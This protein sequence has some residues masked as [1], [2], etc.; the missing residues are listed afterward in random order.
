MRF[1]VEPRDV[2]IQAAARRLGLTEEQF[3]AVADKL[4]DR[5]FPRADPDTGNFD[6]DAI[7]QWRRL[8]NRSLFDLVG[9]PA[10]R[11]AG[12]VVRER[13]ANRRP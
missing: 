3:R 1:H 12:T 7:D 4:Y 8:R 10:A 9:R 5:G 2:P 13:I 11:D 6:L